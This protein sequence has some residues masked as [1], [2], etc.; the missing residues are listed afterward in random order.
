M[1]SLIPFTRGVEVNVI[2]VGGGAGGVGLLAAIVLFFL[3][4]K[5]VV[6]A[7]VVFGIG[8]I[9]IGGSLFHPIPLTGGYIAGGV[10]IIL[11]GNGLL[12]VA[13]VVIHPK[14]EKKAENSNDTGAQMTGRKPADG[15][16]NEEEGACEGLTDEIRQYY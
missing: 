8:V 15:K 9:L 4:P 13:A 5:F 7:L 14:L 1:C 10:I 2:S 11:A 12:V 3:A 16:A 6:L